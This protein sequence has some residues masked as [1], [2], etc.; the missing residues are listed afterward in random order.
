[1]NG[2]SFL[3]ISQSH[4]VEILSQPSIIFRFKICR[5]EEFFDREELYS[6]FE[7]ILMTMTKATR[8]TKAMKMMMTKA[9]RMSMTLTMT[10]AMKMVA[11]LGQISN[12][13]R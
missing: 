7:V 9:M 11:L 8:M 3:D 5:S 2:E 12:R 6:I 13:G 10:K 4:A 1:M